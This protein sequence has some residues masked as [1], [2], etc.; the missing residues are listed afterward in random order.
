MLSNINS[1]SKLRDVF[2]GIGIFFPIFTVAIV[3]AVQHSWALQ[4]D[5]ALI[6][7]R[8]QDVGGQTPLVGA[9]S[10]YGWSHP[11]PALFFLL[12]IPANLFSNPSLAVS[13]FSLFLKW[14]PLSASF[15]LIKNKM[16][17]GSSL[18]FAAFSHIFL[19]NHREE[20]WTI[21][22]P[23]IGLCL[24]IFLIVMIS[25]Y[26]KSP[27][28]LL[29]S[30]IVASVLIQFHI[31]F[32]IPTLVIVLISLVYFFLRIFFVLSKKH[33]LFY[34]LMSCC[35][36][37]IIWLPS[38]YDQIN[39][40]RNFSDLLNFFVFKSEGIDEKVGLINAVRILSHQILPYASWSGRSDMGYVFEAATSSA[41]WF[42]LLVAKLLVLA[43]MLRKKDQKILYA[44]MIVSLMVLISGIAIS[45]STKPA[46]PY[47]FS[48]VAPI[49]M[50]WWL[51]IT[52]GVASIVQRF[53]LVRPFSDKLLTLLPGIVVFI[54][55]IMM[56]YKIPPSS[57]E[58]G[59]TRYLTDK[60]LEYLELENEVGVLHLEGL[61][62]IGFGLTLSLEN[63]GK[64]VFIEPLFEE[65][66][67]YRQ[68]MWGD[69]R[70]NR[71]RP[72]FTV[73]VARGKVIFDVLQSKENWEFVDVYDPNFQLDSEGF[74]PETPF[75]VVALLVR[76]NMSIIAD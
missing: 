4:S 17:V 45:Q 65:K 34:V 11:G 54:S 76:N 6:V 62:G 12:S 31:G 8:S 53:L 16:G 58:M 29:L 55:V 42:F 28:T 41:W 66:F 63:H 13:L 60:A 68:R 1:S 61:A 32:V 10:R 20:I 19:L 40:T 74:T 37:F 52:L 75:E 59:A 15:I 49:S 25:T 5:L 67:V 33:K 72:N 36:G 56:S 30:V 57:Y 44:L 27:W 26:P 35:A 18:L 3:V 21:W 23:T 2:F 14:I 71:L 47:L 73:A 69:H 48:W 9:F 50:L 22:N 24:F 51:F 43:V 70:V 39:G 38:L 46:M 64:K 7:M